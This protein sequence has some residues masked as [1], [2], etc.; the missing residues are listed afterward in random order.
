[1]LIKRENF[2]MSYVAVLSLVIALFFCLTTA[3]FGQTETLA[4]SETVLQ[5][6][7]A[8]LK[9]IAIGMTA[10]EVKDKL[11][12]AKFT[13]ETGFYYVFSDEETMQVTLDADKK[14]RMIAAIYMGDEANAPKYEDV[15]IRRCFRPGRGCGRSA[16]GRQDL[17]SRELPGLGFLGCLQPRYGR[18]RTDDHRDDAK[19]SV[20][21]A[22]AGNEAIFLKHS[23]EIESISDE[24]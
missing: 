15:K 2:R 11:G 19:N 10:D 7:T 20:K 22:A 6:A 21:T 18:G 14:V 12:K 24:C 4:Q 3:S 16:A 5:A 13:D 23:S 1:M 8:N 9:G 17:Q